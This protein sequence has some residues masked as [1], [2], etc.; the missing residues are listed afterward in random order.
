MAVLGRGEHEE[1]GS[2]EVGGVAVRRCA[3]HEKPRHCQASLWK[4][5][6]GG[7]LAAVGEE[8]GGGAMDRGCGVGSG[9]D[10]PE[11]DSSGA[12]DLLPRFFLSK[13]GQK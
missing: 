13:K 3:E 10:E 6:N 1:G 8:A 5:G 4:L 9:G 12:V 11:G 7:W 2:A